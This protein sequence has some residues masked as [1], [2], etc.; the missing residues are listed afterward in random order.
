M[1]FDG[2][3]AFVRWTK[4]DS[5]YGS[6]RLAEEMAEEGGLLSVGDKTG[7]EAIVSPI[8]CLSC[9]CFGVCVCV[10]VFVYACMCACVCVCVCVCVYVCTCV[11]VRVGLLFILTPNNVRLTVLAMV[12]VGCTWCTW[13]PVVCLNRSC[14][15]T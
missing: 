6:R 5:L 7:I 3:E 13:L 1:F 8:G 9:V 12:I 11:H 10:C 2:E 15:T 4:T 14:S